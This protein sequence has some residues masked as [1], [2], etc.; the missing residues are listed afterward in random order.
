MINT[1]ELKITIEAA[2]V[3][4][5]FTQP[6]AAKK[7]HITVPTLISWEKGRSEPSIGQARAMS[8][9]YNIPLDNLIFFTAKS[10]II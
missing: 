10:N 3:N 9:L 6:E 5:G 7:L 2:R 8:E 1:T 4:A